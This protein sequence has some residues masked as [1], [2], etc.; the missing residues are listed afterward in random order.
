MEIPSCPIHDKTAHVPFLEVTDRLDQDN[1]V[2]WQLVRNPASGLIYLSPRPAENE[3]AAYYPAD[4]Y[5]PHLSLSGAISFRNRLYL[6]TRRLLINWKASLIEKQ[7]PPLLPGSTVLE[8]GCSTGELLDA[9]RQR[10]GIQPKNCLGYEKNRKAARYAGEKYGLT[11]QT[12]DFCQNPPEGTFNLLIFWHSLEHL[13]R[14]NETLDI[15]AKRLDKNGVMVITLPNAASLDAALYGPHWVA[16]DPPRHL[17]HFTPATLGKLLNRHGLEIT[18]MHS[19][20][21]DTFYNC[22]YSEENIRMEKGGS[23]LL[24]LAKGILRGVQS[25]AAGM[26]NHQLSSTLLYTAKRSS[27]KSPTS[28]VLPASLS[29]SPLSITWRT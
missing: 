16:W 22:L 20:I 25:T 14:I 3:I 4:S 28:I 19:C 7:S 8:I 27:S 15:A 17:Y 9:I 1:G 11:V 12:A 13:H 23:G 21:P 5:D 29:A 2:K 18:S 26:R 10:N 24:H 6:F